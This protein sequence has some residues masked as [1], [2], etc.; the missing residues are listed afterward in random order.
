MIIQP[1]QGLNN[2]V[3]QFTRQPF[4][5]FFTSA[6]NFLMKFIDLRRALSDLI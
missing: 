6:N 5:L 4:L 3:V 2:F 1:D